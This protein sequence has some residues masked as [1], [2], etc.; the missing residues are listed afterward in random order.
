VTTNSGSTWTNITP[1]D[2]PEG[3]RVNFIDASPHRRGSA[4][5]AAYRYLM[6]DY[7]PYIY[8]TDDYGQTWTKLTN[9]TNGIPADWPT[10]V[11]RE[12]PNREGLLYAGTEFGLF[13]S[14]DNGA[15]WQSFQL[16]MPNVPITDIKVHNKDLVITTQGR[17]AWVLDNISAL[18]QIDAQTPATQPK[19]FA[20][21]DGYRT[22]VSPGTL[23]PTLEYFLPTEPPGD[24]TLEI[25]D[26]HGDVINRYST[27][28]VAGGR[29]GGRA[30]RGGR[31][32]G[33]GRGGFGRGGR[34]AGGAG[35]D[36]EAAMMAGRTPV[37]GGPAAISRLTKN[38]GLN[39]FVWNV[40]HQ[41]GFKVA[42][43][44]YVAKLTIAGTTYTQPLTVLIDPRLA[45]EGM[46]AADLQELFDHNVRMAS[47][48]ADVTEFAGRVT[49][50]EAEVAS[51]PAKSKQLAA[52]IDKMR[53]DP[54]I[55]YSRPGLVEHIRYL[56]GMTGRS[57]QIVGRDALERYE[58]LKKELEDL[59]VQFKAVIG[60]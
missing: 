32:G 51:N 41:N 1:P 59:M 47:L 15:H 30:G 11:V 54:E 18:H 23:G 43:G 48:V 31:A 17:A 42:P 2:L 34:G 44:S 49:Q 19:F 46:T 8:R 3:G 53:A 56:N 16:N 4:Y 52:I 60:G 45:E 21:R 50:A 36:P 27:G 37:F 28:V 25:T 5:Y 6:G 12:D 26:P 10:R 13:I 9:G 40:E 29:G 39:R 33:G 24:V 22:D 38:V 20:P 58:V 55:R 35:V 14:F 7:A 57:D